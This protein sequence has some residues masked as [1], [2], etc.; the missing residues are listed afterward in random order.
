MIIF[1]RNEIKGKTPAIEI[2]PAADNTFISYYLGLVEYNTGCKLQEIIQ[3]QR[4]QNSVP[5]VLILLEHPPVYTIGRHSAESEITIPRAT[6]LIEE[7]S[8][9]ETDRSG[10]ITYHGPGQ[11]VGYPILNLKKLNIS[12]NEYLRKLE[13]IVMNLLHD[14]N[15][16]GHRNEGYSGV[17]VGDKKIC[18]LGIHVSHHITT[19][20]FA[21]NVNNDLRYFE[22][23]R[24]CGL[25]GK[26]ITSISRLLGHHVQMETIVDKLQKH[27]MSIF[28]LESVRANHVWKLIQ[29]CL[30]R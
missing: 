9:F 7:I 10:D 8:L 30:N 12:V 16:A 3:Q 21:L 17:W 5:D 25:P 23:I 26:D 1:D 4:L 6:M 22:Y 2:A 20:G 28:G 11:I 14:F 27:F 18:S 29:D 13:E 15:I 24:P 19:H